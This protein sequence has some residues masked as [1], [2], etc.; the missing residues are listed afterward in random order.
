MQRRRGGHREQKREPK[1]NPDE[2]SPS[3]TE[4]VTSRMCGLSIIAESSGPSHVPM[5]SGGVSS[6]TSIG[7]PKA[8]GTVSA[9]EAVGLQGNVSTTPSP[10]KRSGNL[11]EIFKGNLLEN[12]TVDNSTYAHAQIRATFYPKF[13]NEKSDQEVFY[14]FYFYSFFS[15]CASEF[16]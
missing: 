5:Q 12:F 9:L 1:P 4:A 16:F 13:E 10:P 6:Q 7:K 15:C 14:S 3:S 8:Y 2:S 11:S